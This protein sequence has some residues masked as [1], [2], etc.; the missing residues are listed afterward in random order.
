MAL[1][2]SDVI[3][4]L[5]SVPR[6]LKRL[7]RHGNTGFHLKHNNEQLATEDDYCRH[8]K[9]TED[10]YSRHDKITGRHPADVIKAAR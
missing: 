3:P 6:T 9:S 5:Q 10:D 4:A 7:M 1:L 8:E 2:I